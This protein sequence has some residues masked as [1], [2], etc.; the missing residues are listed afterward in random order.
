MSVDNVLSRKSL[1]NAGVKPLN[2]AIE[3]SCY[4]RTGLLHCIIVESMSTCQKIQVD[5]VAEKEL[6]IPCW[7]ILETLK[8]SSSWGVTILLLCTCLL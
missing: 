1:I 7:K 6:V 4:L 2:G 8:S 5:S 3:T